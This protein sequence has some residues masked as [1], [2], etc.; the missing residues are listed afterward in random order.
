MD[1]NFTQDQQ[2]LRDSLERLLAD[3]YDF[4]SRARHI[5]EP[6]GWSRAQWLRFAEM[7]LLGLPFAAEHGGF[8]GG[9]AEIMIV[10]E[11]FGR[12]LVVEPYLPTVLLGGGFLHEA[13][14]EAQRAA[15]LPRIADG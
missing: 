10:M 12:A 4:S 1:F 11:A 6:E 15:F 7:G 2:M 5:A 14:S 8:E 9:P 3:T 13:G